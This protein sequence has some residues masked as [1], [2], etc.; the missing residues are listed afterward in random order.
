M[1]PPLA[2]AFVPGG[3]SEPR[4]G[5]VPLTRTA[6]HAHPRPTETGML[7]AVDQKAA[8]ER[9]QCRID[10]LEILLYRRS[11]ID[12]AQV[13]DSVSGHVCKSMVAG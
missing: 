2:L 8:G 5:N 1:K 9:L 11:H 13:G 6:G 3:H 10:S 12:I 4:C 7:P